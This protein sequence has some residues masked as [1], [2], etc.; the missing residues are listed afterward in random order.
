MVLS[1]RGYIATP[2]GG[3]LIERQLFVYKD[4]RSCRTA[5]V[6]PRRELV[7]S[8]LINEIGDLRRRLVMIGFVFH[9]RGTYF[10]DPTYEYRTPEGEPILLLGQVWD[11]PKPEKVIA[12]I[13]YTPVK[14]DY[15]VLLSA[16]VLGVKL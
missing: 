11:N 6:L 10:A 12:S 3:L 8:V 5:C 15:A 4:T 9:F 2:S 13:S 7:L 16:G 1:R 14:G